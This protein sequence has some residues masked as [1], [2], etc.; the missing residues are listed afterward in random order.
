MANGW[1]AEVV[2]G[3]EMTK[4]MIL[5]AVL[6][7]VAGGTEGAYLHRHAG[8]WYL[9]VC[10]GDW[11]DHTYRVSVGCAERLDGEFFDRDGRPMAQGAAKAFGATVVFTDQR[12]NAVEWAKRVKGLEL[13]P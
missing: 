6:A 8:K 9:F 12:H 3:H 4:T 10:E 7:C 13:V 11:M 2:R 1:R 5:I